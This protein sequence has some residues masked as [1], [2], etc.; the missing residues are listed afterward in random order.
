MPEAAACKNSDPDELRRIW[1]N[2]II[3]LFGEAADGTRIVDATV[4][5]WSQPASF[6]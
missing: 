5:G 2:E 1:T 6:I 4:V 3:T